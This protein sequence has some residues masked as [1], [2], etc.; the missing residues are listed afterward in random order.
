MGYLFPKVP[1]DFDIPGSRSFKVKEIYWSF[2]D[3][4]DKAAFIPSAYPLK[5]PCKSLIIIKC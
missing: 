4:L 3:S 1:R 5:L 2:V